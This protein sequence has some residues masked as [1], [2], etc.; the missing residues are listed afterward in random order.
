[1]D[2]D[3]GTGPHFETVPFTFFFSALGFFF[4]HVFSPFTM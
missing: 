1:M 3:V 4:S 2:K